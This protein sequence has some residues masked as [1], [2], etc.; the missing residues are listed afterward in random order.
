MHRP[1]QIV[2]AICQVGI[3]VAAI[4][5]S[6]GSDGDVVICGM[7]LAATFTATAVVLLNLPRGLLRCSMAA[8]YAL[9]FA[10]MYRFTWGRDETGSPALVIVGILIGIYGCVLVA[11]GVAGAMRS[12]QLPRSSWKAFGLSR[13]TMHRLYQI[14]MAICQ[15]GIVICFMVFTDSVDPGGVLGGIVVAA[16]F[17]SSIIILLDLPRGIAR[18]SVA[19]LYA[20]VFAAAY[21]FAWGDDTVSP[22]AFAGAILMG[23]YG[24]VIVAIGVVTVKWMA[25]LLGKIA[26][27]N[28]WKYSG[29]GKVDRP[30][31]SDRVTKLKL[32]E[33]IP[34]SDKPR[35]PIFGPEAPDMALRVIGQL[36]VAVLFG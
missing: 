6:A 8:F 17:T 30:K 24:C 35:E 32:N 12:A 16:I 18:W 1:S 25:R 10:A 23:L 14:V 34:A 11:C 22:R 2:M 15:L 29:D 20:A 13:S 7:L 33:M 21:H 5:L 36:P 9:A 3:F 4:A 19:A 26:W 31:T 27:K 28:P